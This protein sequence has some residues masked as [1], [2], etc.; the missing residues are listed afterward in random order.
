MFNSD[1][2]LFIDVFLYYAAQFRNIDTDF[3]IIPHAKLNEDQESYHSKYGWV[4]PIDTIY[5]NIVRDGLIKD[6]F[7]K[8]TVISLQ[9]L[10][11]LKK[12]LMPKLL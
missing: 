2:S 7:L 12:C 6:I 10:Q 1:Q 8:I 3:G 5:H 11:V 4:E 9:K